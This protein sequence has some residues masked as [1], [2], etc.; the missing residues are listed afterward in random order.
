ML[1]ESDIAH[2]LRARKIAEERASGESVPIAELPAESSFIHVLGVDY[3]HTTTEQGGDLYLTTAGFPY[4]RHL[5]PENWH[6]SQWFR[7]QRERLE[8]TTHSTL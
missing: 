5:Q 6:D 7:A 4:A 3:I 8:G 2:T 1:V